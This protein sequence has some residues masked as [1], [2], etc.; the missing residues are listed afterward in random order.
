MAA[1]LVLP[2]LPFAVCGA[3]ALGLFL[4]ARGSRPRL[5][6]RLAA[7]FFALW[8]F[9]ATT[10]LLWVL[11][12]GGSWTTLRTLASEP[13]VLFEPPALGIWILGGIGAL[14]V[15]VVAFGINQLVARGQLRLLQPRELPW[16]ERLPRP[17]T[18]TFLG[19]YTSSRREAFSFALLE[20]GPGLRRAW[21]RRE[22]ILVS[23][24]L[25]RVLEP[26]E[27]EAVVAHELGHVRALDSR[28]LT[29]LRTFSRV[30]PWDPVVGVVATRLTRE[31]ELRSDRAAAE[32][33]RRP[34]ALARAL[35]KASAAP[36]G[37]RRSPEISGLLGSGRAPDSAL[38]QERIRR[39]W[40]LGERM[41][42]EEG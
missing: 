42:P 38:L 22:V 19:C 6:L 35:I 1:S 36:G 7:T 18:P 31:E 13:T 25:W 14:L 33:T 34:R 26:T 17:T 29:F 30:V 37:P 41:G 11:A 15:F 28:Y 3:A 40:A 21:V 20:Q 4:A 27:R 5:L 10:A 12:H 16:P 23:T 39:L 24:G 2:Y 32:L 8:A 9:L